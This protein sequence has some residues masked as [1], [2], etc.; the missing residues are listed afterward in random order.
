M[1]TTPV[2]TDT[3]AIY[4]T[5]K[6]LGSLSAVYGAAAL[7]NTEAQTVLDALKS[8]AVGEAHAYGVAACVLAALNGI[9]YLPL[10]AAGVA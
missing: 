9:S 4:D 3:A 1:S 5:V 10:R 7:G 6:S 2:R 8:E